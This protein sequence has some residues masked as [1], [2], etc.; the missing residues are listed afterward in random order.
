MG[1]KMYRIVSCASIEELE[2]T[3]NKLIDE[4][5]YLPLGAPLQDLSDNDEEADVFT[6]ALINRDLKK[7]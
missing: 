2:D 7:W 3:V 6:Q 5:G 1:K 4:E